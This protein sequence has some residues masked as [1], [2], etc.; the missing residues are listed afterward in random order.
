MKLN[1]F[2]LILFC[3]V[4]LFMTNCSRSRK[5]IQGHYYKK[6]DN[7]FNSGNL[8]LRSFVDNKNTDPIFTSTSF[9]EFYP[10]GTYM[11][12]LHHFEFGEYKLKNDSVYLIRNDGTEWQL[13][14]KKDNEYDLG[15]FKFSTVGNDS[16]LKSLTRLKSYKNKG[17]Y[18]YSKKNNKWRLKEEKDLSKNELID[19]MQNYLD[20]LIKY[21]KWCNKEKIPIKTKDLAGPIQ[22]AR[23]GM[24]VNDKGKFSKWCQILQEN[25]CE[26]SFKLLNEVFRTQKIR[27][28]QFKDPSKNY[29]DAVKQVKV[30]LEKLKD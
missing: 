24:K 27:F 10:D 1:Y 26:E 15:H 11:F 5:D 4:V 17:S 18:P 14:Y 22:L 29:T 7:L 12:D 8:V 6:G 19:K 2:R 16:V 9:M 30:E 23:N 13:G 28:K 21:I 25:N 20:F 3:L